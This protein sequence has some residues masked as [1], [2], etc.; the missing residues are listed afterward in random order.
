MWRSASGKHPG[1]SL[2]KRAA[3]LRGR[4]RVYG[5]TAAAAAIRRGSGDTVRETGLHRR[6]RQRPVS[7]KHPR[8]LPE[9]P[10]RSAG[11]NPA[12]PPDRGHRSGKPGPTPGARQRS[13]SRKRSG[14]SLVSQA[15]PPRAR[16]H[17]A[18]RTS[19]AKL[20][21]QRRYGAGAA[22]RCEKRGYTAGYGS[23]PYQGSSPSTRL[24]GTATPRGHGSAPYQGSI[25]GAAR[26]ANRSTVL[27]RSASGKHPR[28]LPE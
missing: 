3:L 28:A 2:V 9:L 15:A 1:R 11:L 18:D 14:R 19:P 24:S 12:H 16:R 7:G 27:W 10:D 26:I 17:T 4:Q 13:I 21:R 25:P 20:R 5:R 6:V 22:I 23:T 8:A